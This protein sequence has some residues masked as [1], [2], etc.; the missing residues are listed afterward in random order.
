MTHPPMEPRPTPK[1]LITAPL[2]IAPYLTPDVLDNLDSMKH[3]GLALSY[4]VLRY[5]PGPEVAV[6]DYVR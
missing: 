2:G 1:V 5:L 3:I 6:H 4:D